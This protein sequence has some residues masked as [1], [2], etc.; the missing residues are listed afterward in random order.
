MI[1]GAEARQHEAGRIMGMQ[2]MS[3]CRLVAGWTSVQVIQVA[4]PGRDSTDIKSTVMSTGVEPSL[5]LT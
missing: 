2:G 5:I 1:E 4:Q 3:H